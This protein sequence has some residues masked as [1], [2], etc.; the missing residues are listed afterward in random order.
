VEDAESVNQIALAAFDEYQSAYSDWPSFSQH[1]GGMATLAQFGEIVVAATETMLS[2]VVV[3]VGPGKPKA[4][5]FDPEWPIIR[6]LVVH[7]KCRGKGLGRALTN[8]CIRRAER[9]GSSCI[10]LH[11]TPIMKVALPMYRRMGFEFQRDAPPVSGVPYG[12]YLKQ[13]IDRQGAPGGA[14][15]AARP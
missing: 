10:A 9:D 8:E 1:I 15:K 6:M 4:A 2:G 5:F 12:I 7:P 3:Y 11:T 14:P 13:L